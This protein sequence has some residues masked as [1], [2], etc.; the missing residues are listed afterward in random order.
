MPHTGS[1]IGRA[2]Q[3]AIRSKLLSQLAPCQ[4]H[5]HVQLAFASPSMAR[6]ASWL[7]NS[8]LCF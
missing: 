2:A 6:H 4:I 7:C 8:L 3:E 1:F 5:V